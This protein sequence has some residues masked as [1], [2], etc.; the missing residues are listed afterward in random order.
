MFNF[1]TESIGHCRIRLKNRVYE[2][3]QRSRPFFCLSAR[4]ASAVKS[5]LYGKPIELQHDN[6]VGYRQNYG[7]A[8]LCLF[9][10]DLPG[11]NTPFCWC[12]HRT[13]KVLASNLTTRLVVRRSNRAYG[14]RLHRLAPWAPTAP[15]TTNR[16]Y[17]HQ[18][19]RL[20]ATKKRAVN[21][22]IGAKRTHGAT[23]RFFF[24]RM[25]DTDFT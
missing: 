17:G 20:L 21:G 24:L 16:A 12:K 8:I 18:P 15:M 19:R 9:V 22:F 4:T 7:G 11:A 10:H 2:I 23:C 25:T 1:C 5:P 13:G 14:M 3:P 6:K